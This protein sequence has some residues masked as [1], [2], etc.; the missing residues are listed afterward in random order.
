MKN[1]IKRKVLHCIVEIMEQILISHSYKNPN[2]KVSN[3][4]LNN[5]PRKVVEKN[6]YCKL[7]KHQIKN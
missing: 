5:G 2:R 1:Y 3:N 4:N 7:P 6:F